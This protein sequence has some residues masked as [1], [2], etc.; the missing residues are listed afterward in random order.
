[1]YSPFNVHRQ[2]KPLV[3]FRRKHFVDVFEGAPLSKDSAFDKVSYSKKRL[4]VNRPHQK[5]RLV[6]CKKRYAFLRSYWFWMGGFLLL[7]FLMLVAEAFMWH[8]P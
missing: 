3:R 6:D 1:M 4:K 7:I 5:I 2:T 8:R